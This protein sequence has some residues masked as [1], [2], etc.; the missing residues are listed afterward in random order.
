MPLGTNSNNIETQENQ[1]NYSKK[2]KESQGKK[3]IYIQHT[4]ERQNN[5]SEIEINIY[6]R[7]KN[8]YKN[9]NKRMNNK[10]RKKS[11]FTHK[12]NIE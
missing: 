6:K 12:G 9:I 2:E 7:Y 11:E 10:R 4:L 5:V 1:L 3:R 8:I